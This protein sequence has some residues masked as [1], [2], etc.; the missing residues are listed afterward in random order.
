MNKKILNFRRL[1]SNTKFLLAF[2]IVCAFVFWIVVALE[3]AP[4]V[5]NVIEGVPVKIDME[6]SV[7]DRLGLQTFTNGEYTVDI[8]VQ[9]NRYD[10]GGDLLDAD[11]FIVIAQTSYVDS[12][13]THSLA[14]KASIKDPSADYE[15]IGLSSDYIEVYFDRYEEKELELKPRVLTELE[16]VTKD[17]YMFDENDIILSNK[18]VKISGAKTE[19][20]KIIAA[21]ADISITDYLDENVTVDA[22]IRL[23]NGSADSIKHVLINGNITATVPATLPVYKIQTLPVSVSFKNSPSGYLDKTL[24]YTCSPATVKVAVMQNGSRDENTLEV[25]IIDFFEIAP[26]KSDF[27]FNASELTDVKIL[28]G[29]SRF[30]V[31]I[32]TTDISSVKINADAMNVVITGSTDNVSF[33]LVLENSGEVTVCGDSSDLSALTSGNISGTINL[34][35]VVVNSTA[36]RVPV[37]Y[38]VKSNGDCWVTGTYFALIKTK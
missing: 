12:S 3:Y 38:S 11:D 26:T 29:T 27:V 15:I 18:T 1:F 14:V 35:N 28:D 2:S 30:K 25:G 5:E 32:D 21:Y 16:T 10:I 19:V 20:D 9:G 6:N 37:I 13:G 34:N 33:D 17:E 31:K 4:V 24:N 8:T 36:T 22:P 23:A 7:P